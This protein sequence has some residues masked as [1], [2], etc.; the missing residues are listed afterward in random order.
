MKK[1]FGSYGRLILSVSDLLPQKIRVYMIK[2]IYMM[3]N[4]TKPRI[5]DT[6]AQC[7]VRYILI[8][9]Q[10]REVS[11]GRVGICG[12]IESMGLWLAAERTAASSG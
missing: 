8:Q 11:S 7:S 2:F 9:W 6:Q 1:N 5:N 10:N 3:K 4:K 12:N